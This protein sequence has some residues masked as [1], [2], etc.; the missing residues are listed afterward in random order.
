MLLMRLLVKCFMMMLM[1]VVMVRKIPRRGGSAS[2]IRLVD[3]IQLLLL[4]QQLIILVR[5]LPKLDLLQL[6][7]IRSSGDGASAGTVTAQRG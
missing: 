4:L 7:M 6:A 5:L 2:Y 3:R 1:L